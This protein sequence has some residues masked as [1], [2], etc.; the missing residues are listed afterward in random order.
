M[1]GKCTLTGMALAYWILAVL[2][3][4]TICIC[5]PHSA[6]CSSTAQ[7]VEGNASAIGGGA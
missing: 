5:V 2:Y 1:I 4:P 3:I 7:W 6:F